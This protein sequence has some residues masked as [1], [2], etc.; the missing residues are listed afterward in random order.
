MELSD[1]SQ[2][3]TITAGC[4]S[5]LLTKEQGFRSFFFFRGLRRAIEYSRPGRISFYFFFL[6][7]FIL[8]SPLLFTLLPV[9]S[10]LDPFAA[11]PTLKE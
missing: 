5:L 8:R 9:W 6:V 2:S 7:S 3:I 4:A 1:P 11:I 10:D